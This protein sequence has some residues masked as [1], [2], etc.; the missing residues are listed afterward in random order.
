MFLSLESNDDVAR[1]YLLRTEHIAIPSGAEPVRSGM[2]GV[3]VVGPPRSRRAPEF[4]VITNA[5][6]D[7]LDGD[8]DGESEDPHAATGISPTM[9]NPES[10]RSGEPPTTPHH[11]RLSL[12]SG[13]NKVQSIGLT[14][15][16][17]RTGNRPVC[18]M[19]LLG[20]RRL[21]R[22][23]PACTG[24]LDDCLSAFR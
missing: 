6:R 14:H 18:W 2:A 19:W 17:L 13:L 16:R 22:T 10:A 1:Y 5:F 21:E 9:I 15:V 4:V 3:V 8:D 23:L 11:E 20:F 24:D 7:L 12:T